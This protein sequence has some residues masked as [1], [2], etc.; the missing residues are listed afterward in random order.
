MIWHIAATECASNHVPQ[1][2]R[3][4]EGLDCAAP[5]QLIMSTLTAH[6]AVHEQGEWV[7]FWLIYFLS[8]VLGNSAFCLRAYLTSFALPGTLSCRRPPVRLRSDAPDKHA[9]VSRCSIP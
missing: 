8:G 6:C 1:T 2:F 3:E 4:A 5:K 7:V 9:R